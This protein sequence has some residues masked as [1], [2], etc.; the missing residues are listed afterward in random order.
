M[1]LK[2]RIW[3][4]DSVTVNK[5]HSILCL[6]VSCF[7]FN[8]TNTHLPYEV[9][10]FRKIDVPERKQTHLFVLVIQT[11]WK[12]EKRNKNKIISRG[13]WAR[14]F[15]SKMNFK[16]TKAKLCCFEKERR[17]FFLVAREFEMKK[18]TTKMEGA[19]VIVSYVAQKEHRR[20]YATSQAL[21]NAW[22]ITQSVSQSFR[23]QTNQHK[24]WCCIR[25]SATFFVSH[26]D[27]HLNLSPITHTPL[28]T[29]LLHFFCLCC[30]YFY[31]HL[32]VTSCYWWWW[33]SSSSW[34][35]CD[36]WARNALKMVHN[37]NGFRCTK[38]AFKHRR[39]F[40]YKQKQQQERHIIC[41]HV[42]CMWF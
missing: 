2:F 41:F 5:F 20:F 32:W 1:P 42:T 35:W 17:C 40:K 8:N 4:N 37:L 29:L 7:R 6:R 28:L 21:I 26:K 25:Y 30:I 15:K 24:M 11:K 18:I 12:R 23:Q 33:S 16:W 39:L 9:Y 31:S 19:R 34:W 13:A 22:N 38:V 27:L 10:A 14:E 3:I 36:E